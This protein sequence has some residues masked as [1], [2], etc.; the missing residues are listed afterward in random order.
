MRFRRTELASGVVLSATIATVLAIAMRAG[1]ASTGLDGG[2]ELVASFLF[3]LTLP[4]GALAALC[5]RLAMPLGIETAFVVTGVTW[6]LLAFLYG[7]LLAHGT[8]TL[9]KRQQPIPTS[10]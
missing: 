5:G 10:R 7:A 8:A 6:T 1:M 2:L 9:R 3:L 4:A